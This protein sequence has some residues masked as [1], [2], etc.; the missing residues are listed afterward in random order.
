MDK[1]ANVGWPEMLL[2]A[3]LGFA[4]VFAVLVLLIFI[5]K[6]MGWAHRLLDYIFYRNAEADKFDVI[7][8]PDYGVR[9]ISDHYPIMTYFRL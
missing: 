5:M 1:F 4:V 7:D 6:A 3:G 9:F 2:M 8:S